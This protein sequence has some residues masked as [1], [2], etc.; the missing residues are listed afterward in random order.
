MERVYIVGGIE[1]IK[2][3]KYVYKS[4]R[5]GIDDKKVT[6]VRTDNKTGK[7]QHFYF[8]YGNGETNIT[9]TEKEVPKFIRAE[10]RK[11]NPV[12]RHETKPNKNSAISKLIME[13]INK[14]ESV[15][16]AIDSVLGAGTHAKLAGDVYDALRAKAKRKA[17]PRNTEADDIAAHELTIFIQQDGSLY[18]QM[19]TPIIANLAKKMVKGQ[20]DHDKSLVVWKRLADEGA[21]RY[22]KE[23]GGNFDVPTRKA[24]A[25]ELADYYREQ[26]KYASA[27][28]APKARKRNPV[29]D[30]HYV[31]TATDRKHGKVYYRG[32]GK[33][34]PQF[35]TDAASAWLF[36]SKESADMKARMFRL[37]YRL[38]VRVA[39]VTHR[40]DREAPR[41]K[42]RG[43]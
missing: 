4:G 41:G 38:P 29:L 13:R 31:I 36:S 33:G 42:A 10:E 3:R 18:R 43:R 30:S 23:Y 14:G 21:K 22:V 16:S 40:G 6:F 35:D 1:L 11:G 25:E 9:L 27:E 26:V 19:V 24:A 8:T 37:D 20:Y 28:M 34:G 5:P 15:Q 32:S 2:G 17:N 12:M 39:K 7:M